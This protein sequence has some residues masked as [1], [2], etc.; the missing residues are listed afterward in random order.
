MN[1]E[2]AIKLNPKQER[3]CQEYLIDLN[4]TA[5]AKRAGYS[6]KTAMEQGYQLLRNTSVQKHVAEL[7][8][9]RREAN[10]ATAQKVVEE[11]A[12]I[13]FSDIRNLFNVNNS[14][15]KVNDLGKDITAAIASIKVYEEKNQGVLI[16]ETKE[17][18]LYDKLKALELL[19]RHF[20]I[21]E[22]DNTQ[23]KEN[24][25]NIIYLGEGV[26]PEK[27]L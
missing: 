27:E 14:L 8:K 15:S 7:K 23:S 24:A 5:A 11:L 1:N 13:A 16:G 17:I 18:K 12:K 20:G 4:A 21:F 6:A 19:G 10:E 26:C 22:K 3:F 2:L 9:Q 25:I